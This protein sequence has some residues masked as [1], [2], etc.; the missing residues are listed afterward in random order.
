MG[1]SVETIAVQPWRAGTACFRKA[2]STWPTTLSRKVPGV[3]RSSRARWACEC[4]NGQHSPSGESHGTHQ[5]QPFRKEV[6][7]RCAAALQE[8]AR[9]EPADRERS[10]AQVGESVVAVAVAV[11]VAGVLNE[12]RGRADA[13]VT[14]D[15]SELPLPLLLSLSPRDRLAGAVDP[16]VPRVRARDAVRPCGPRD[17]PR[18]SAR[19]VVD[20][21]THELV[22]DGGDERGA[23][24]APGA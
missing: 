2:E 16:A 7:R 17:F 19:R 10:Q 12:H 3:Q 14:R 4:L 6:I 18:G 23:R 1:D 20:Q 5:T 15:G 11:A 24:L 22:R 13:D 9:V 21:V 8:A